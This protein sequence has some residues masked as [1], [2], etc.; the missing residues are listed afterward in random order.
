MLSQHLI[1]VAEF[2]CTV[3]VDLKSSDRSSLIRNDIMNKL[4]ELGRCD[5]LEIVSQG[6]WVMIEA[7]VDSEESKLSFPSKDMEIFYKLDFVLR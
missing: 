4:D 2:A 6:G 3:N 5:D 1:Q 7:L